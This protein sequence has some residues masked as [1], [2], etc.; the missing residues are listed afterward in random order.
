MLNFRVPT[1]DQSLH[2][3]PLLLWAWETTPSAPMPNTSVELVPASF[4]VDGEPPNFH[5]PRC[6][7]AVGAVGVGEDAVG[8]ADRED[9]GG[10]MSSIMERLGAGS[11]FE[12][13]IKAAHKG[14]L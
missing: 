6:S 5:L 7:A 4:S 3:L 10:H 1:V 12:A 8:G 14:W 13:G 2:R 11:R 9:L